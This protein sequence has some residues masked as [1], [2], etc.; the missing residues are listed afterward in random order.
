[1]YLLIKVFLVSLIGCFSIIW[2]AK[3]IDWLVHE[4]DLYGVQKSHVN[5]TPSIGGLPVFLVFLFGS[6]NIGVESNVL[7][8]FLL[9]SL[10]VFLAGLVEDITLRIPPI[11]RL[12]FAFVS[13]LMAHILL[14]VGINNLGFDLVDDVLL[15]Y[16]LLSLLFTLLVVGGA[17]NSLNIIDGFNGLLAGY[18]IL[19]LLAIAYVSYT[20]NDELIVQLSLI[21]ATSILG[22]FVFNFPFGKIFMGDGGAYFIGF[23]LAVIGLML[24]GRHKELSNWFVLLIFIYPM[25]ELLYSMY[26]RKFVDRVYIHHPDAA[27]LHSLVYRKVISC[28]QFKHN[29][30]VCN[31]M[32]AIV[33]LLLPLLSI[34]PAIIWFNNQMM[35]IISTLVF[36]LIYTIIYKYISSDKLKFNH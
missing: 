8:F 6:W 27:H 24:V 35:L 17:I 29:K 22:F 16:S 30:V 31:S 2:L 14:G 5:P 28:D 19:A 12:F 25:Y 18:S 4:Q 3:K 34:I 10:P 32:T 9:S 13:I 23:S 15:N 26:R 7:V 36:M 20:L 21:L 33:M 11:Q 1:M